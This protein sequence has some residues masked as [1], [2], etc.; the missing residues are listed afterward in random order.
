MG[1]NGRAWVKAYEQNPRAEVVALCDLSPER[2][3]EALAAHPQ[4]RGYADL[5]ELLERERPDVL[6]VH[7]PDHLHAGP[8]VQG[9]EAGCHVMCEKPMAN[10]LEDLARMVQAAR[11]S[12]R[13]THIGQILRFNPLFAEIKRLCAEGVLGEIF[14]LE[15]DYIHNLL[16]QGDESRTN[17]AIGNINWYLEHE[18][19]IV[20]GGV[21]QLDLLRWFVG[22]PITHACGF[23]NS[24]AFGAM[25]HPDCMAALFQFAGGAVAK[26]T[27]LYGPV[28]PRPPHA[29][30]AIYGTRGTIRDGQLMVG[31]V[32][33]VEVRDLT[34][35]DIT[36]HPYDPQV[37]HFLK[38]IQEGRPSEVDALEGARS[39]AAALSAAEAIRTARVVE[40]PAY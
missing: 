37:E 36:G 9:L 40:V 16:Y 35:L 17:P 21:H 11:R 14:Y 31:E 8:F 10:S 27:A 39:A 23:G 24:I 18:V 32:H 6:S 1:H 5:G 13:K 38:C 33:D 4:A 34:A 26:V 20:G 30:L 7:T 15:A 25:K 19:P 28:G 2:L 29:N 12:D 22:Q 3:G